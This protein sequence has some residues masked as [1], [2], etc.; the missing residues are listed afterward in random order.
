MI[1]YCLD[2]DG[3]FRD[4]MDDVVSQMNPINKFVQKNM[5]VKTFL[6]IS[7]GL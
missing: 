6:Y 1:M 7:F 5:K 2:S 4:E 3:D